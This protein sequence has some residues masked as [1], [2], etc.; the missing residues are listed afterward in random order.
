MED[1]VKKET[2]IL[3]LILTLL[4]VVAVAAAGWTVLSDQ[5]KA[6]TDDLFFVLVCL[7]LALLFA[8]NPLMWAYSKGYLRNPL[9]ATG[10]AEAEPLPLEPVHI[11][12][13]GSTKLFIYVWVALLAITFFE[14]FLAYINMRKDVMLIILMGGSIVKAALIMAYFMHLRFERLSLVLTL[15]PAMVVCLTLLA[16]FFPDSFRLYHLRE[17]LR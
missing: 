1:T 8:I 2:K 11:E 3:N 10:E 17:L 9:K 4:A 16:I 12:H 15:V 7:L 14:V 13:V 5:F 6:G